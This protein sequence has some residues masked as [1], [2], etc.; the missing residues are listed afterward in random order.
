M[1]SILTF[2]PCYTL[3]RYMVLSCF[4]IFPATTALLP[5]AQK[6]PSPQPPSA[7]S[8]H[9]PQQTPA[10]ADS[11]SPLSLAQPPPHH[12]SYSETRTPADST[13]ASTPLAGQH[14]ASPHSPH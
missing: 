2:S 1:H 12:T 10:L 6:H 4:L 5:C 14:K 8:V 11:R 13:E 3:E 9:S 7:P